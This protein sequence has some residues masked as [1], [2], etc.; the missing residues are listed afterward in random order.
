MGSYK[1]RKSLELTE[2]RTVLSRS[3]T[4]YDTIRMLPHT[5]GYKEAHTVDERM[6]MLGDLAIIIQRLEE[7]AGTKKSTHQIMRERRDEAD[8]QR[9]AT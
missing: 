5:W 4:A 9:P 8:D 3:K 6:K 1:G 7:Y 2:L